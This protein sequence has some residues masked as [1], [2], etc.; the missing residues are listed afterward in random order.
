[1]TG[2]GT[3]TP[4]PLDLSEISRSGDLF[5]ALSGRRITDPGAGFGPSDDPAGRLLAALAADVDAGAPPL[6]APPPRVSCGGSK[7]SGR[8]VVRAF[9]TFGAVTVL[10]TS[11]GAAVAGGGGDHEPK[12]HAPSARREISERS[13]AR[14]ESVV[15]AFPGAARPSAGRTPTASPRPSGTKPSEAPTKPP[16]GTPAKGHPR[17][18]F[19]PTHP[20]PSGPKHGHSTSSSPTTSPSAPTGSTPSPSTSPTTSNPSGETSATDPDQSRRRDLTSEKR[21]S[22]TGRASGDH[23]HR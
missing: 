15:R 23:D 2:G 12:A 13:R 8:P 10:L 22:K 16:A 9:V 11:A 19:G 17:S 6:P 21:S 7:T 5:D 1:M 20:L 18:Y 4:E 14:L 3:A